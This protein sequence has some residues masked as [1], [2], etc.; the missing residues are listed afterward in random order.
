MSPQSVL[1]ARAA[2]KVPMKFSWFI[3][4]ALLGTVD[5]ACSSSDSGGGTAGSSAGGSSAA[6]SS[7]GGSSAAGSSAGG[8]A[9]G[10]SNSGGG[11]AGSTSGESDYC[12]KYCAC[13]EANCASTAI[14]GGMS[15]AD[16]CA[17]FPTSVQM[18]RMNMCILQPAQPDNNHCAHSV[19][20]QQCLLD[21]SA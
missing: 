9:S 10:G 20:I 17:T 16:F 7:T 12:V 15:C 19:G 2:R 14:P 21:G 13:H 11:A 5:V 4:L 1:S 3:L 6:G 18:C 8:S